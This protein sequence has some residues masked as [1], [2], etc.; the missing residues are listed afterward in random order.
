MNHLSPTRFVAPLIATVV[1]FAGCSTS[2]P[3]SVDTTPETTV[4]LIPEQVS[5]CSLLTIDELDS[6]FGLAFLPGEPDPEVPV[7]NCNWAAS[8]P[9]HNV[10][11]PDEPFQFQ[12]ATLGLT[13]DI[14]AQIATLVADPTTRV[15]DAAGRPTYQECF[16][17]MGNTQC[18]RYSSEI[19]VVFD[20]VVAIADITNFST[21]D[22]FT[23]D[24]VDAIMASVAN[25]LA[26]RL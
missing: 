14:E 17:K 2:S 15:A 20:D 22:D 24:E 3:D 19:V 7:S 23:D 5:L 13:P 12:L 8:V 6:A 18:S 1:L 11:G 26:S 16:D 10:T 25:I 4:A 21:P 9:S